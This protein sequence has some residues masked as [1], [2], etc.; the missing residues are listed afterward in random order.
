MSNEKSIRNSLREIVKGQ[1][2]PYSMPGT[3]IEIDGNTCDVQLL[4]SDVIIYDVLIT[5]DSNTSYAETPVKN[6]KCIISFLSY[7]TAFLV[8]SSIVENVS[9]VTKDEDGNVIES[10]KEVLVDYATEMYD[11]LSQMTHTTAQGPTSSPPINNIAFSMSKD[12]F[13]ERINKIFNK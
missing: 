11:N 4:N 9:I 12:D 10:L 6:S 8:K 1:D 3:I 13:I 7:N 5:I 2:R